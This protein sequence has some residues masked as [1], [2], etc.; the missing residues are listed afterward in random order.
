[1][2]IGLT[3]LAAFS[4]SLRIAGQKKLAGE[5]DIWLASGTRFIFGLPFVII[6]WLV[7]SPMWGTPQTSLLF[8]VYAVAGSISQL[9]A[10]WASVTLL[11][12]RN[13][14][15][16]STL[17]KSE[18]IFIAF[19][20]LFL[21][22]EK[23]GV[24]MWLAILLCLIGLLIASMDKF[25]LTLKDFFIKADSISAQLG[26]FAGLTFAI[27]ALCVRQATQNVTDIPTG[28]PRGLFVLLCV[29][30]IQTTLSIILLLI[31]RRAQL[32]QYKTHFKTSLF[33]GLTSC[34]GS[35]GWFC[36]Y[37]LQKAA[38]VK[39]LG[40][41]EFVFVLFLSYFYFKEKIKP[42]EGIAMGFIITSVFLI[43]LA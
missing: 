31:K 34:I 10:T 35:F 40:Q 43:L 2:W 16:G 15:I 18:V 42:H 38:Y 7:L 4:Q 26:L 11:G 30:V 23:L 13:F 36:A 14:A 12:R 20:G 22:E 41:I 9:A 5:M 19:L 28:I 27:T 33:V 3:L 29:L 24:Q 1:M 21:F 8:W 17:I 37:A 32:N 6:A 25:N 39:A